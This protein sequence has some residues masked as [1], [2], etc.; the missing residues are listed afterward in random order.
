MFTDIKKAA[1][2][3]IRDSKVSRMSG[4]V[5][6]VLLALLA[7]FVIRWVALRFRIPAP[8]VSAVV[9]V[10]VLTVLALWGQSQK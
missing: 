2:D 3:H 5:E 7:A 9:I 6:L 1:H 10:F 4:I 8:T